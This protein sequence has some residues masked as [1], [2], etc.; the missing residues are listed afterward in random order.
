M[1]EEQSIHCKSGFG[2]IPCIVRC[3]EATL[4]GRQDVKNPVTNKLT[5]SVGQ[6]PSC[7]YL[8]SCCSEREGHS[9]PSFFF[10]CV[11]VEGG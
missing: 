3:P 6:C 4:C 1:N 9:D 2:C 7:V 10:F 8:P 5:L 11:G